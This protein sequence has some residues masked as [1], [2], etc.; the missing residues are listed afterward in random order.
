MPPRMMV[1][2]QEVC[3]VACGGD[4][5]LLLLETGEVYGTGN[6][7]VG[8]LGSGTLDFCRALVIRLVWTNVGGPSHSVGTP[9]RGRQ[10][11]V[12]LRR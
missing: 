3:Q 11:L 6:N 7:S 8:Q 10:V 1:T 2:P 5:T 12:T 9:F 4:F